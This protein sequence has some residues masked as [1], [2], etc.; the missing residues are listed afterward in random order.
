MNFKDIVHI[1]F[2]HVVNYAN[3]DKNNS[4]TIGIIPSI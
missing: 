3:Q 1:D 2:S 4:L